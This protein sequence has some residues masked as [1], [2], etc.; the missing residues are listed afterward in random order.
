MDQRYRLAEGDRRL[1]DLAPGGSGTG[2]IRSGWGAGTR[3][4]NGGL[5]SSVGGG[6][7]AVG[8]DAAATVATSCADGG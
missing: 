7:W 2:D 3:A 6:L 8:G 5:L 1:T 4:L